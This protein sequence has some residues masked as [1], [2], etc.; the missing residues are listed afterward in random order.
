MLAHDTCIIQALPLCTSYNLEG[1]LLSELLKSSMDLNDAHLLL[2][3]C[4]QHLD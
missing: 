3:H 1:R 4:W 2:S